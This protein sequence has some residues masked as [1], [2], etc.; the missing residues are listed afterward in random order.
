[1]Q[2]LIEKI[3]KAVAGQIVQNN[4]YLHQFPL[5]TKPLQKGGAA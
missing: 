3:N 1:M 5:G 2:C 4:I